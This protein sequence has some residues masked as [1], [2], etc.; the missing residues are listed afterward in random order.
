MERTPNLSAGWVGPSG[1]GHFNFLHRFKVIEV[2]EGQ[3][4]VSN[5][6]TF[7]FGYSFAD[8]FLVGLN[9]AS[10][11]RT[12]ATRSDGANLHPNEWEG[13]FR[14]A[15][16]RA[17]SG[18][19]LELALTAAYNDAASSIDGE[20]S[21][22]VPL[23]IAKLMGSFR[24]LSNAFASDT[25][26]AVFGGG[27][28]LQVTPNIALAGD[29][30]RPMELRDN[31]VFGWGL[32]L[33]LGIP[34]TPHTISLHASNTTTSTLQG[35][36]RGIPAFP[37]ATGGTRWGFEFTVPITFARYFGGGSTAAQDVTITADTVRVPIRDFEFG[38]QRLTVRPGTTVV[39]INE[40]NTPHTSTSNTLVWN[41]PV[42]ARG[43]SYSR[44]F[45]EA[46]EYPYHCAP[47]PF[48]TAVVVVQP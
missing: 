41:S 31:E 20:V 7:L 11:S 15:P 23:G 10:S 4:R 1:T 32:G 42:L 35:S 45:G 30:V 9:Y 29:Y 25:L 36:S 17:G 22:G 2:A 48:M 12:D 34:L 5:T 44:V 13:F 43:E 26:R 6:P 14:F 19:P 47:H 33:Q 18:L 16:L 27:I 8:M 3:D 24:V 37:G 46:G 28:R 38:I 39:W 21:A 40:G